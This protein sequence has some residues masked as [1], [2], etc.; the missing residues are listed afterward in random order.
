MATDRI[1]RG[2]EQWVQDFAAALASPDGTDLSAL[3][4]DESYYRDT[5]A[6]TWDFHQYEGRSVIEGVLGSVTGDLEPTNFRLAEHWP[7]PQ[8]VDNGAGPAVEIFFEFDTRSAKAIALMYGV[9][10][11]NSPYGFRTQSLYTRLEG[12]HGVDT[13]AVH[14]AGYGYTPRHTGENWLE[15][16]ERQ[17]AFDERE[18]EV[19]IVGAGQAGLMTAAYLRYFGVNALV[20]DKHDRVGD[21]WRKRYSSLFLHN[22]INMNH[23]PMLRFPEHYPQYLPKDVLGEWL[24]TYSRYLDL[25]VWT[26][27]DFVGGEYDEANKS[28]SATVVTAS[29][30]KRVL[31]PRHIVLATGGIGGK[32]NVPNLPGLDKFAGKVMHS[33]EFHDSDEYQGKSAIVIGMGSSAHDIAR[34]LCNHG[35]KVTMVQRSPVV[36]NSVEIANSAYAAGYADGVPIELGDIR[37]GLALINSL[38]VASSKMAHQIGKEADAELHRGLEAAGVVLGDGH[39]NSGWLDL[40]L[41]T[42]GGYYLNAG[43]S[44]L[45]ISGDIKVIQ[46]DQIT[47]FTEAGAQLADGTTRNADL[48]LLATGYQNRKV[49]VAEQ[50]GQEVADRVGDIA[51]LTDEGEW[52]NMWSQTAQRGLWFSGGGIPQVRPGARIL[53]LLIKADLLELIPE[54][55]RRDA[56]LLASQ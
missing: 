24:E 2:A 1:A 42:G 20:I 13:P 53:A 25:D 43:A 40:F 27:T 54:A 51:R 34:D 3:F 41:R 39:D 37:Y 38:R 18:L 49:E 5:G 47:T 26:S 8:V 28:W 15:H 12:I 4:L 44:E 10:D 14:P 7:A 30:E 16:R 23:F 32:P 11:E 31:H 21:N 56:H 45:I 9:P 6:L 46:A 29:G 35:A 50:F 48:V 19:L 22:T 17:R 52:A 36:I 55:Y 33:S